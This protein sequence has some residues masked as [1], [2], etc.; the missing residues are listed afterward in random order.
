MNRGD[1][2]EACAAS[3]PRRLRGDV[4]AGFLDAFPKSLDAGVPSN[5]ERS[6]YEAGWLVV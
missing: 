6:V 1:V 3:V 4:L 5:E 2:R